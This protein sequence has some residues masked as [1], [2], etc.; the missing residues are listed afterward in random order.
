MGIP[1]IA[2]V[3][4]CGRGQQWAYTKTC[5]H[6]TSSNSRTG[7]TATLR[8]L[9]L[10]LLQNGAYGHSAA[11]VPSVTPER[12]LWPLCGLCTFRYSRTGPTATIPVGPTATMC[13]TIGPSSAQFANVAFLMCHRIG[14]SSDQ[15]DPI[16]QNL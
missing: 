2:R 9:Y 1:G 15:L 12:G 7:P 8:P 6:C 5:G 16:G 10:Q 13:H 14:H 3:K 11:S 4:I